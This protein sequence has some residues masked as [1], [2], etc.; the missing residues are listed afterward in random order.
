[1]KMYA[2]IEC[3]SY[4][5]SKIIGI[6]STEEKADLAI[7]CANRY[8]YESH[9]KIG[10][11]VDGLLKNFKRNVNDELAAYEKCENL[12]KRMKEFENELDGNES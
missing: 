7:E 11:E 6:C 12:L 3:T 8:L 1:M 10:F 5:E 2:I 9:T 4:D